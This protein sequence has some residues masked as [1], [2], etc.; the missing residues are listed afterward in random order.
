MT[1]LITSVN[2]VSRYLRGTNTK[3]T[4]D[5]ERQRVILD[6]AQAAVGTN[7]FLPV[8]YRGEVLAWLGGL[9]GTNVVGWI[10]NRPWLKKHIDKNGLL[11]GWTT[12]DD[13]IKEVTVNGK[14][15]TITYFKSINNSIAGQS[16]SHLL[17]TKGSPPAV[18]IKAGTARTAVQHSNAD[19][20]A[21]QH[22][23]NV[24]PDTKH[25][26]GG[27][28]RA[29]GTVATIIMVVYDL[30]L[31]YQNCTWNSASQ[32]NMTNTLTGQRYCAS[33]EPGLSLMAATTLTCGITS[34]SAAS[35]T[36]ND[37]NTGQAIPD[38]SSITTTNVAADPTAD[39]YWPS[40]F[41][42]DYGGG[43]LRHVL[44]V[45]LKAG[46]SGVRAVES[47]T[48]ASAV[49]GESAWLLGYLL[50]WV[51]VPRA[52][53]WAGFDLVRTQPLL[54]RIVDGAHLQTAIY[55]G[56]NISGGWSA[57]FHVGWG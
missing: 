35:Y 49:T 1:E 11:F 27:A 38:P 12:L 30:V 56:G 25:L 52:D 18:N 34:L 4:T 16:W 47:Y 32:Q 48:P 54:P 40:S 43:S 21:I 46:D 33:G 29:D 37:G 3:H 41:S 26:L 6:V 31:S 20:G 24:S 44:T 19:L 53:R 57:V 45:P 10:E 7:R 15:R 5:A 2:T 28:F 17:A 39:V 22:G 50:A 51:T 9:S 13:L 23:G 36:D 14:L 55:S 42:Q 8:V